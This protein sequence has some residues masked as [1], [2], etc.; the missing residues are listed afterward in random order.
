MKTLTILSTLC[1]L[2]A[3]SL[4]LHAEDSPLGKQMESMNSAFKAINKE[5]DPVKGA[6]LARK[7]QQATLKGLETVPDFILDMIP[8]PKEKEKA[9]AD[10]RRL[11]GETFVIF[12]KMETAFLENKMDEVTKLAAAA[13]DLKKEG[14]KKYIEEE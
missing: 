11:M 9:I 2:V 10:Y 4:P 7:A 6:E 8:D 3:T 14:H 12:C 1:V 13:K 5:K